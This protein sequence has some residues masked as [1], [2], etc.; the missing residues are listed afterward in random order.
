[1]ILK[2]KYIIDKLF[3]NPETVYVLHPKVRLPGCITQDVLV[4]MRE[5]RKA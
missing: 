3:A 4:I 5:W 2:L 1:M